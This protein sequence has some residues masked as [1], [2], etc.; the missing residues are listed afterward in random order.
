MFVGVCYLICVMKRW[1]SLLSVIVERINVWTLFNVEKHLF[2]IVVLESLLKLRNAFQR[3]SFLKW[4]LRIWV[5]HFGS[6]YSCDFSAENLNHLIPANTST[7]IFVWKWK[8]SPRTF[9]NV[10][11]TLTKQRWNN[12]DRIMLIQRRWTNFV[13]TLK[14]DWKSNQSRSMFIDVVSTLTKQRWNNIERV[15]SIQRRC[16]NAVSEVNS[17]V[18]VYSSALLQNWENSIETTLSIPVLMFTRNWFKNKTKLN[19]EL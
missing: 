9:I 18:N 4:S 10:V 1:L 7:L 19:F 11:S 15:T 12:V 17:S 5:F 16:P 13:S 14:F 6:N 3:F 8:L 2:K